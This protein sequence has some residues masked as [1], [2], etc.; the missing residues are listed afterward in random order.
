MILLVVLPPPS[1]LVLF[2]VV[3][4]PPRGFAPPSRIAVEY[5]P[6]QSRRADARCLPA[7]GPHNWFCPNSQLR[8]EIE[9][10]IYSTEEVR[11][12]LTHCSRSLARSCLP[13][14]RRRRRSRALPNPIKSSSSSS[15]SSSHIFLASLA[16][17]LPPP[18]RRHRQCISV[19]GRGRCTA[20]GLLRATLLS[21]ELRDSLAP[22][23]LRSHGEGST[24]FAQPLTT[25]LFMGAAGTRKAKRKEVIPGE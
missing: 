6:S 22:L 11:S 10:P 8:G 1:L 14:Q 24:R 25:I 12:P 5:H 9:L 7:S 15:S 2:V 19:S 4:S 3:V 16:T 23:P 13:S 20:G 21:P 17:A 18:R